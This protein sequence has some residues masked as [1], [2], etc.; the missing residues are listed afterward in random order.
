MYVEFEFVLGVI[1]VGDFPSINLRY[2]SQLSKCNIRSTS[3]RLCVGLS[4]AGGGAV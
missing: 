2:N 3:L 4:K 1:S